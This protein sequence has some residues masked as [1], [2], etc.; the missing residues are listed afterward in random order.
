MLKIE[1]Y[2]NTYWMGKGKYQEF[3]D[4]RLDNIELLSIKKGLIKDYQR[5]V[6]AYKRFHNDGDLPKYVIFKGKT[7]KEICIL[8]E[9]KVDETIE[10]IIDALGNNSLSL[11]P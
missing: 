4:S 5:I 6:H 1:D 8:L 9:K 2:A 3:V 10:K 7:K 11:I